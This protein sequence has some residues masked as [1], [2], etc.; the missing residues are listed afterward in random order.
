MIKFRLMNPMAIRSFRRTALGNLFNSSK[1]THPRF[2]DLAVNGL[3]SDSENS[4]HFSKR[5][6]SNSYPKF[7]GILQLDSPTLVSLKK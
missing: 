4:E 1:V 7:Q 6:I 2:R 5:V 3:I